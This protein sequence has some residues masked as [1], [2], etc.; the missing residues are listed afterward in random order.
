MV[1]SIGDQFSFWWPCFGGACWVVF[2]GNE[3]H[4]VRKIQWMLLKQFH[5]LCLFLNNQI[6]QISSNFHNVLN[7][8]KF[9]QDLT[10]LL[11]EENFEFLPFNIMCMSFCWFKKGGVIVIVQRFEIT[12]IANYMLWCTRIYEPF[13][14]SHYNFKTLIHW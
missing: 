10:F 4:V 9:V 3:S 6:L 1:P 11:H 8:I 5:L 13:L 14:L 12:H 7:I 2:L